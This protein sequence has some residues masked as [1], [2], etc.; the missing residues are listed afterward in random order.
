MAE[1]D[2]HGGAA[3]DGVHPGSDVTGDNLDNGVAPA[4][5]W[6]ASWPRIYPEGAAESPDSRGPA[7]NTQRVNFVGGRADGLRDHVEEASP[8]RLPLHLETM[9]SVYRLV[10]TT[11]Q[12]PQYHWLGSAEN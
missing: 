6:P 1:S 7:K 9:G 3:D 8:G 2:E 11:G 4:N 5:Y 12:G 10:E